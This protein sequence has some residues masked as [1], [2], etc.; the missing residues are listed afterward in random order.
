MFEFFLGFSTGVVAATKFD[1][2]PL[3][4]Y[5]L[6]VL[7]FYLPPR[8]FRKTMNETAGPPSRGATSVA[9]ESTKP[10]K[11]TKSTEPV[12]SGSWSLAR[13]FF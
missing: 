9:R 8:D 7:S 13:A 6:D 3:I 4:N 1:F 2:R 10:T 12:Q 5:A 11:P